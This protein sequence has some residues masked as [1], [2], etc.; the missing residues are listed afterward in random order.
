MSHAGSHPVIQFKNIPVVQGPLFNLEHLRKK[1]IEGT[2]TQTLGDFNSGSLDLLIGE[3]MYQERLRI[4]REN[5]N[6]FT[7]HRKKRDSALWNHVQ[8]DLLKSSAEVD[9]RNI[10]RNVVQHY[11]EEISG[12]FDPQVYKLATRAVPWGFSW[13]LNAASVKRFLPWKMTESLQSRIQVV[14]EIPQLQKLA[15]KG[16][17]LMVPT[18]QSNIDSIL[19]GYVIYLMS[20]PPFSYG[21]GLNLYSNPAFSFFMSRLGAYT[22]DRKK[23]NEIY[24]H[25]LKN[26]STEV[27]KQGIHTIFFPGGG[28]SRS[29]AIESKL[30]LGL[31]G[32]ALDAQIAGYVSGK[33]NPNIYVVPM[34]MSYHFVL[35]AASLIEDYLME[36]GKHR[37]IIM[38]DE[39]WQPTKVARFFWKM[40]SSQTAFTVRIGKAMDIFG[41]EVN[42]DGESVGPNGTIIDPKKWLI[43][44]GE[45]RSEPQRDREYTRQLGNKIMER[46]HLD[47]TVLTSHLVA[48]VL[49]ETL[50]KK[51]PDLDLYRFLRL[52]LDQRS[53]P[54]SDFMTQ[55]KALHAI[56]KEKEKNGL[57][58]LSEDLKTSDTLLWVKNGVA[59][60]G[61]IHEHGVAKIS[62]NVIWT[63]DMN[64][65]YYYRNRLTGYSL[66]ADQT[67]FGVKTG[68]HDEKGFLV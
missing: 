33:P 38:D 19:V 23:N 37:Y 51:Y 1:M 26:Y 11:V 2:V 43:T 10:L 7:R 59:Q 28:R 40:F 29:G 58:H 3:A 55:A 63:E 30:K 53:L 5:Y 52:S 39:S 32:T 27:L 24:K 22:V 47:N 50:R 20:L 62:D 41:N 68:G 49:F 65:L 66:Q 67:K 46:F 44:R 45:I 48:F 14:G 16:T 36:A 35:E 18:H 8:A 64:L 21:A 4:K 15:K 12:H 17:I 56:L 60:L 61:L 25:A 13:M 42:E 57:L 9:R 54:L 34:V 31:L 6:L